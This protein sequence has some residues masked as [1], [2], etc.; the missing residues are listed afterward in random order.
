MVGGF[1]SEN[2]GGGPREVSPGQWG[3]GVVVGREGVGR[4]LGGEFEGGTVRS[5]GG[6]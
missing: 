1:T 2:R 6:V 5:G 4:S 3:V